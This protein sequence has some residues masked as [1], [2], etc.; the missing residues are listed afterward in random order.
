M[1][2][3]IVHDPEETLRLAAKLA[4][5]LYPG[6]TVALFGDVGAGKTVF[7]RGL[8]HAFGIPGP[9][10]SPTYTLQ[11]TYKTPQHVIHHLDLYRLASSDDVDMLDLDTCW[12]GNAITI[13]EWA[14]RAG[15]LLPQNTWRVTIST[16]N[17]RNE[18]HIQIQPPA[19]Q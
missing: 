14:E 1:K 17:S 16:G 12:D 4:A 3:A 9:I 2:K 7:A 19:R 10:S 13:I 6:D 18:R 5:Q 8:A 11:Q 15:N